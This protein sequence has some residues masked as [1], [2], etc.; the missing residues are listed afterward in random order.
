MK[1]VDMFKADLKAEKK[2]KASNEE[3]EK[4]IAKSCKKVKDL[5]KEDRFVCHTI[6][7][8]Y[9]VRYNDSMNCLC[10]S[11]GTLVPSLTVPQLCYDHYLCH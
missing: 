8:A 11:V 5:N 9:V 2:E 4:M 1:V 10:H 6:P 3:V 7:F